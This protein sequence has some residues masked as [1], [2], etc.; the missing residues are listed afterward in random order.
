MEPRYTTEALIQV[1]LDLSPDRGVKSQATV[2]VDAAE[3]VG[4]T[5]RIIRSRAT[6]DAVVA[7][8]GLDKDPRFERRPLF[9]RWLSGARAA[10]GLQRSALTPHDLAV[11]ALMRQ[12]RVTAEPRSYLIS[13]A[14]TAGDPDSAVKLA[15]AVTAEYLRTQKLKELA[16]TRSAAEHELADASYVYGPRHPS[17]LSALTKVEQQEAQIRTV[18]DAST[19]EDLIKLA[20]GYSLIP[21]HKVMKPSGPNISVT[22]ALAILAGL[23]LGIC[24][25]RY[26]PVG[27]IPSALRAGVQIVLVAVSALVHR[28]FAIVMT[29]RAAG[30]SLIDRLPLLM[31]VCRLGA[32][33][34]RTASNNGATAGRLIRNFAAARRC[35]RAISRGFLDRLNRRVD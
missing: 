13:V 15:N 4:T 21:A 30:S 3:V 19:T 33:A 10:L 8:L 1:N 24:L 35:R 14:V 22:L 7:R 16:E 17:Y 6:A 20:A 11:D 5:A 12:V 29:G 27:L 26:T 34:T 28:I 9:S 32:A 31:A 23:S 25:T 18:G 2:S